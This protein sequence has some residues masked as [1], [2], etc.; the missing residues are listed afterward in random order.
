MTSLTFAEIWISVVDGEEES[1]LAVHSFEDSGARSQHDGVVRT[2]AV[3]SSFPSRHYLILLQ[4]RTMTVQYY[5]VF[6][7]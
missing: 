4:V 2:R 1:G 7:K 3:T 6:L 5:Y